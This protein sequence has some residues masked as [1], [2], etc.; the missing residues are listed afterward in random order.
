VT[1]HTDGVGRPKDVTFVPFY[2]LPERTYGIYWDL[3]APPE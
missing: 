1:F 2:Q 3:L